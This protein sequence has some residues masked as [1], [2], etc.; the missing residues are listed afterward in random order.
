M[1]FSLIPSNV[2]S[3]HKLNPFP[4]MIMDS[5]PDKEVVLHTKVASRLQRRKWIQKTTAKINISR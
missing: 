5:V 2:V 3:G 1:Y 4:E